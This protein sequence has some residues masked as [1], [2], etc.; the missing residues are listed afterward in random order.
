MQRQIIKIII[1]MSVK[2]CNI[3]SMASQIVHSNAKPNY[4]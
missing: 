2:H 4:N 1:V 3:Y